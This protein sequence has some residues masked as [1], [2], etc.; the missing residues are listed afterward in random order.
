MIGGCPIARALDVVLTL[1]DGE[2]LLG[3]CTVYCRAQRCQD[4]RTACCRPSIIQ[5]R[6]MSQRLQLPFSRAGY[7]FSLS[8]VCRKDNLWSCDFCRFSPKKGEMVPS[9][10][11]SFQLPIPSKPKISK[12]QNHTP[13][14]DVISTSTPIYGG[15]LPHPR[16]VQPLPQ[17]H[18]ATR[19]ARMPH[20]KSCRL[21]PPPD[22]SFSRRGA[23]TS[24]DSY[25][26]FYISSVA[27]GG[28]S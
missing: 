2:A 8:R 7:P 11:S 24:T 26:Y 14:D 27:G 28:G 25:A 3:T 12:N 21:P 22:H 19:R 15:L 16:N 17:H 13:N 9:P 4:L 18:R 5:I 6:I 20:S 1:Y 10:P 23:V